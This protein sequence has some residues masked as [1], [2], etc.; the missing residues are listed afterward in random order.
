MFV[1]LSA[2]IFEKDPSS[3][4]ANK[5]TCKTLYHEVIYHLSFGIIGS[6]MGVTMYN[7]GIALYILYFVLF[8]VAYYTFYG[9]MNRNYKINLKQLITLVS[10]VAV[11]ILITVIFA[12]INR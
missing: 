8:I 5:P 2:F 12:L 7:P 3:E 10:V 9:L 11:T 6:L 1:G 4:W